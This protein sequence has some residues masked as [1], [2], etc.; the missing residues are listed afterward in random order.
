MLRIE[1]GACL[2]TSDLAMHTIPDTTGNLFVRDDLAMALHKCG[3]AWRTV[4]NDALAPLKLTP[5]QWAVLQLATNGADRGQGEL[6]EQLGIEHASLVR[7]LDSLE[8]EGWIER[9]PCAVD[10]RVKRVFL[11]PTC[12]ARLEQAFAA[13]ENAHKRAV[14]RL[15]LPQRA[16][17]ISL[18]DS[19]SAG[20]TSAE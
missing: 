15:S 16:Q 10:R 13:A 19:M 7:V 2:H 11:L 4:L 5:L 6:A 14:S 3:Q 1:A 20:L 18:L 8:R 12:A 9:R 17:L